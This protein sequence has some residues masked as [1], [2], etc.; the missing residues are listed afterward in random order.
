MSV[1]N[2]A[3]WLVERAKNCT[4]N[5]EA[6]RQ[7]GW[8]DFH[9]NGYAERGYEDPECGL[10][11][12]GNWNP[13]WGSAGSGI[14][15]NT[16][17][18]VAS[19]LEKLDI[20]LEW[21]DEWATCTC[22]KIFRL[23]PDSYCWT[24][25]YAE[26]ED[27]IVCRFC[28]DP[29]IVLRELEGDCRSMLRI[30]SINPEDHRYVRANEGNYESGVYGG[31]NDDPKKIAAD[32]EGQGITRYLFRLEATGQFD[33][34][35]SVW[36]HEDETHMLVREPEGK[37]DLDPAEAMRM[38]LQAG[39]IAAANLQGDGIKLVTCNA[40]GTADA[41]MVSNEEFVRGIRK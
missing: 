13:I 25:S 16:V 14:I 27:E 38:A 39:N 8:I 24:P 20:P 21:S 12:T 7:L 30:D 19:L 5:R 33:M 3:A 11:A 40:D 15:D 36:V 1:Y 2:R 29:E 17:P 37:A 22:G 6:L 26:Q 10:I 23:R 31:Q 18:R 32:L 35:F 41:R 28:V 9:F 4:L 34:R